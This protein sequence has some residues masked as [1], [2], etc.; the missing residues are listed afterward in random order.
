MTQ[1][2]PL[3]FSSPEVEADLYWRIERALT[4]DHA[5]NMLRKESLLALSGGITNWMLAGGR[6]PNPTAVRI[7]LPKYLATTPFSVFGEQ[8]HF[9]VARLVLDAVWPDWEAGN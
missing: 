4:A 6:N 5:M 8:M 7:N 1:T 2:K 3:N 9:R